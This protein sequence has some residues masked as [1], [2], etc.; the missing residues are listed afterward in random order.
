[1]KQHLK[2][3]TYNI[4]LFTCDNNKKYCFLI[5]GEDIAQTIEEAENGKINT[6]TL[7]P[8]YEIAFVYNPIKGIIDVFV[9]IL[10]RQEKT[11][12]EY[13]QRIF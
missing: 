13:L 8:I 3:D 6:T 5:K 2:G 1:M 9:K 12:C 7:H 4:D 11:C 10:Q